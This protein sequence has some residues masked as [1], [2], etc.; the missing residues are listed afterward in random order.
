M[1]KLLLRHARVLDPGRGVD[2]QL[3]VAIADGKIAAIAKQQSVEP[4][5]EVL[6]L[7]G[8][9]VSPGWFDAHMHLYGGLG[10]RTPACVGVYAGVTAVLDAGGSGPLTFREFDALVPQAQ[11]TDFY[12]YVC[13]LRYAL[14]FPNSP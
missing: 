1:A 5:T 3:D 14:P 13:M 7:S 9:V 10:M 8:L 2:G 6:D 11:H 4:D 12:C